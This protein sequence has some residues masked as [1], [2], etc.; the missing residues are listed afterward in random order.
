[1]G[2]QLQYAWIVVWRSLFACKS[3]D[4]EFFAATLDEV[5]RRAPS[6]DDPV[7]MVVVAGRALLAADT[8]GP[9]PAPELLDETLRTSLEL[10]RS[11]ASE[12]LVEAQLARLPCRTGASARG[13]CTLDDSLRGAEARGFPSMLRTKRSRSRRSTR[14]S[15]TSTP[16]RA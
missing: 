1:V 15:V 3:A 8:G 11:F 9:A 2:S 16:H 10:G 7:Q 5:A 14:P 6:L 12:L 4:Y 13:A